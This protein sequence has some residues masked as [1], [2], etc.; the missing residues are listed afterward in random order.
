MACE[1]QALTAIVAKI[2][3]TRRNE[4]RINPSWI[5]TEALL[6][7]DPEKVSLPLVYLGCHLELRQN[8]RGLL[9]QHFEDPWSPA[10]DDIAQHDLFPDLQRRYPSA[11]SKAAS[12][13][14]YV[15]LDEMTDSD[16]W[17]NV[18]RLRKEGTTKLRHADALEA[19]GRDKTAA[20]A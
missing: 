9:R 4:V 6:E 5:A 15:L 7:I 16:I 19:F 11:R 3:E 13:P 12:E 8:A 2:I 17:F 1:T 18:G 20:A 10:D 14:E